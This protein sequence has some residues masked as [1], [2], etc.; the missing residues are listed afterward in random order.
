MNIWL[1]LVTCSMWSCR[2]IGGNK[3]EINGYKTNSFLESN[4]CII[5]MWRIS[6]HWMTMKMLIHCEDS[7]IIIKIVIIYWVMLLFF[8]IICQ[9]YHIIHNISNCEFQDFMQNHQYLQFPS[10]LP[11]LLSSTLLLYTR[12]VISSF[13]KFLNNFHQHHLQYCKF[14]SIESFTIFNV[15]KL[16]LYVCI[17]I[18]W[19]FN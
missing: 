5:I 15:S 9:K 8:N 12:I 17:V 19:G 10:L 16:L 14:L 6:I 7:A 13:N 1:M 4:V 3:Q 2:S 11:S 18:I